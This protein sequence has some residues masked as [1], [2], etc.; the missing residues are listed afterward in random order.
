[1]RETST[2]DEP[3]AQT[4]FGLELAHPGE[5]VTG[6]DL[7]RRRGRLTERR[8]HDEVPQVGVGVVDAGGEPDLV[9]ASPLDHGVE[10]P[11]G[12]GQAHRVAG[13]PR[14]RLRVVGRDELDEVRRHRHEVLGAR[15]TAVRSRDEAVERRRDVVGECAH[16]AP[17]V[18]RTLRAEGGPCR[19]EFRPRLSVTG[20]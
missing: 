7:D 14:Q 18:G 6:D 2:T 4:V 13:R 8:R 11:A 19:S 10:D 12:L 16:G 20:R 9:G 15:V 5:R 3:D 17:S 1:M